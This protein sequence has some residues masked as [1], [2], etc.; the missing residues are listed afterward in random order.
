MSPKSGSA[1]DIASTIVSYL[2]GE[3]IS[4]EQ[5]DVV[6]CDGTNTNTGWKSGA[7]RQLEVK[8]GRPLQWAVC[9]LHFIELPFR[10]LF[11][12]LD[13]ETTGPITKWHRHK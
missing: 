4:L 12:Y 9:L 7:I 5:L 10:H 2:I 8:I 13:G 1:K 3:E 6:G 11:Q